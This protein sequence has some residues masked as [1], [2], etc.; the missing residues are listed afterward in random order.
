M[1][2]EVLRK[3]KGKGKEK[4]HLEEIR[5]KIITHFKSHIGEENATNPY[6]IFSEV[7]GCKPES[8]SVYERCYWWDVI[9]RII[10][11]LRHENKVFV[12][13]R[14]SDYFVLKSKEECEYYKR[15]CRMAIKGMQKSMTRAEEWVRERKWKDL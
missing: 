11:M 7:M 9:Q 4:K 14:G 12:I 3:K 8:L 15:V 6:S 13:V 1:K 10:R 5:E 2:Q